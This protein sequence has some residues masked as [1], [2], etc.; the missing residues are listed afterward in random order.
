MEL[1]KT[2]LFLL[3]VMLFWVFS[4]MPAL[5]RE[6]TK[7]TRVKIE[8][9]TKKIRKNFTCRAIVGDKKPFPTILLD[10]KEFAANAGLGFERKKYF[11]KI[12]DHELRPCNFMD[13]YLPPDV[14]SV[15]AP[16]MMPKVLAAPL[17]ARSCKISP[18]SETIEYR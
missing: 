9:R 16:F 18:D 2:G 17:E 12:G 10:A 7:M 15:D 8:I 5:S 6:E 1:K 3:F 14:K 13:T 4:A 11:V